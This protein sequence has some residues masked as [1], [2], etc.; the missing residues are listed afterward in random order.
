[1]AEENISIQDFTRVHLVPRVNQGRTVALAFELPNAPPVAYGA[2]VQVLEQLFRLIPN[3]LAD[4]KKIRT[5]AGWVDSKQ[6]TTTPTPAVPWVV[7]SVTKTS[8]TDELF[9]LNIQMDSCSVDLSLGSEQVHQLQQLMN[10]IQKTKVAVKK[11]PSATEKSSP[12]KDLNKSAEAKK[13]KTELAKKV[14]ADN[15][16]VKPNTSSKSKLGS[17]PTSRSSTKSKTAK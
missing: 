16:K 17:K 7:E 9:V 6:S 11:A 15:S 5:E 2:P 1:M 4:A 10:L 13:A 8:S 3:V 14:K 12:K